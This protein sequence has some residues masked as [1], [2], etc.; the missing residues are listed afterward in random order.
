[1]KFVQEISI[2]WYY[3][4]YPKISG[5]IEAGL[6]RLDCT[7]SLVYEYFDEVL[8]KLVIVKQ[9]TVWTKM[10]TLTNQLT[11]TV[12]PMYNALPFQTFMYRI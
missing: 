4:Q 8:L 12:T 1:M 5:L 10:L 7:F 2:A 6:S 11:D 9:E 3:F